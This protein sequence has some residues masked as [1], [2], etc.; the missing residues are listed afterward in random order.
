MTKDL[1]QRI[2]VSGSRCATVMEDFVNDPRRGRSIDIPCQRGFC[3]VGRAFASLTIPSAL[4]AVINQ[5]NQPSCDNDAG[6]VL[7]SMFHLSHRT[8]SGGTHSA[9]SSI[10]SKTEVSLIHMEDGVT[11][12]PL[13]S[14]STAS[15]GVRVSGII[16]ATDLDVVALMRW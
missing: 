6:T 5:S 7:A 2:C 15:K 11:Q 12:P 10:L 9:T 16:C 14:S 8:D 13:L 1:S 3:M 4:D